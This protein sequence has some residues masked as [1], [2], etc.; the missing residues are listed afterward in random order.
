MQFNE[1][2]TRAQ[3]ICFG[4]IVALAC[5]AFPPLSAEGGEEIKCFDCEEDSETCYEVR[6]TPGDFTQAVRTYCV[7]LDNEDFVYVHRFPDTTAGECTTG[8]WCRACNGMSVCHEQ[9]DFDQ[10]CHVD[11]NPMLLALKTDLSKAL[12]AGNLER[13][14]ELVDAHPNVSVSDP[15]NTLRVANS[16]N[17]KQPPATITIS[18]QVASHLRSELRRH[19]RPAAY[20]GT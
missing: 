18:P 12:L 17:P 16:C 20:R 15:A 10:D 11:C 1:G 8:E 14:L 19:T 5:L 6:Q 7:G 3:R 2:R 13:L 4:G 9:W